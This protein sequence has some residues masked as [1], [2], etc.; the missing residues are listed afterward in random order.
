M[1]R[2]GMK[3]LLQ[4]STK[5]ILNSHSNIH[6]IHAHSRNIPDEIIDLFP[7]N[8]GV[9]GLSLYK[10]FIS[11][12]P[13]VTIDQY[14]EQVGYIVNRIGD[15]YVALGSDWHGIPKEKTV[16]GMESVKGIHLLYERMNAKLGS[17][18]TEKFFHENAM[19][20]IKANLG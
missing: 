12:D 5:P 4:S 2:Q 19:R 14:V 6:A 18:T 20:V 8:G 15:D 7:K 17:I 11:T 10:P 3:E 16:A 1:S 9:I 13:I